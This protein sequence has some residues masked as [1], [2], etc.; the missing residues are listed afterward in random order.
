MVA[1][2]TFRIY[3]YLDSNNYSFLK[4]LKE[5]IE[6]DDYNNISFS[7]IIKLAV[8]ELRKNNSYEDIK[9]KLIQNEMI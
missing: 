5:T 6:S 4:S 1:V 9:Q 7:K 2:N 3:S 8:I